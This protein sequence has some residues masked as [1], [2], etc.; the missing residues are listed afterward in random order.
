MAQAPTYGHTALRFGA[1]RPGEPAVASRGVRLATILLSFA[2]LA[3]ILISL[4][5]F[6]AASLVVDVPEGGDSL[7]Q[8]GFLAA[9]MVYMLALLTLASP[10]RLVSLFTP[11]FVMLGLLIA[12]EVLRAP[13]IMAA[14]RSLILTVIG[15]LITFAIVA[16]PRTDWR[17]G[18]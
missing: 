5:P 3:L 8:V 4:R 11:G 1:T 18:G 16:L 17:Y 2:G 7:K 15:M 12:F 6:A 14:A 13:D 9:G 10:K